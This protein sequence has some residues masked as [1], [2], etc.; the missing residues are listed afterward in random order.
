MRY[1]AWV[2]LRE[3]EEVA[4]WVTTG[5]AARLLGV[6]ERRVRALADSGQLTAIRIGR[7]VLVRR[8]AVENRLR[9]REGRC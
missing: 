7:Q 4:G 8:R 3:Q 6:S 1:T 2:P 9:E 5:L